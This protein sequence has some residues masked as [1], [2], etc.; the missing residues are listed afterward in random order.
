MDEIVVIEFFFQA[1]A[2]GF[3]RALADPPEVDADATAKAFADCF[4]E[5]GP[6]G[7]HCGRNDDACLAQISQGYAFYRGIGVRFMTVASL[8]PGQ[9]DARHWGVRGGWSAAYDTGNGRGRSSSRC[10]TSCR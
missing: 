6:G 2:A 5:A 1:C 10:S 3:A 8:A 9:L 7:V 4:V